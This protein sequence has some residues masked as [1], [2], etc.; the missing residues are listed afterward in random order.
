[1]LAA[2]GAAAGLAGVVGALWLERRRSTRGPAD[3]PAGEAPASVELGQP[4]PA[5]FWTQAYPTP[6]GATLA[7]STWRGR[8]L[9]LNFWAT[10]CP[11]CVREMPA[12]DAFHRRQGANGCRVL[13]LAVDQAPAVREFLQRLPVGYPIVLAGLGGLQLGRQLGNASGGLPFSVLIAADGRMIERQLGEL[14]DATLARWAS[15]K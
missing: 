13:G 9:L 1:M 5:S 15:L 2:A 11:P 6:D 4:L 10:W 14:P 3:G 7:L 8:P 12:L